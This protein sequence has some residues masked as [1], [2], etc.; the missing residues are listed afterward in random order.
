MVMSDGV[1]ERLILVVED[2]LVNQKVISAMIGKLGYRADI[3]ADGLQ[4]VAAASDNLY[5]M[6]FMDC[7]MPVMD[8]YAA[9]LEIR[10]AEGQGTSRG[11]V[12]IVAMTA[13]ALSEDR[14]QCFAVGMDDFISKPVMLD[15]LKSIIDKWCPERD[16][17]PRPSP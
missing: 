4:A 9:T 11:R 5:D 3:V 8:G 15:V 12:P 13:N 10:Q 6:I 2:N 14:E 7:Q 17:N 16:S 1:D